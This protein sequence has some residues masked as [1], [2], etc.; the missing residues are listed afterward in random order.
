MRGWTIRILAVA[1]CLCLALPAL[2]SADEPVMSKYNMKIWGRVKMDYT[3]D[4]SQFVCYNDFLG[5]PADSNVTNGQGRSSTNFNPRDT[6]LGFSA[7]HAVAS[8]EGK[9]VVEL[10]FYGTNAGNN[11]I[12]RMRLAYVDLANK[13]S[14][15]DVRAGQDWLPVMQLNPSTIDFGIL[16]ATGNLW[17]RQ[18]QLT[19]RQNAGDFQFLVS[20]MRPRRT[21]TSSK[22]DM[23]WMLARA[24][25]SF[26]A[27]GGKHMLAIDGG[28]MHD[29]D[30]YTDG[31][32]RYLYGAEFKFDFSPVLF[33]GEIW[34]GQAIGGNFLRYNLDTY[35]NGDGDTRAWKAWGGW[36]DLTYK[37][38]PKLS[39]TAGLGLDNPSNSGYRAGSLGNANREFIYAYNAYANTWYTLGPDVKVGFEVMSLTAKRQKLDNTHYKDKGERFTASIYYGF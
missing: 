32:D 25:Y 5:V 9:G 23:P 34:G 12:P 33:K 38:M 24:A 4:T 27:A 39:V 14:G 10:D 2:A 22:T 18:P 21:D 35:T 30:N 11:L 31:I 7:S 3:Y 8:W 28:Y 36:A 37:I 13:D 17:W 16:S 29:K 15:T 1:L 26:D 20:A 19:L 6:R